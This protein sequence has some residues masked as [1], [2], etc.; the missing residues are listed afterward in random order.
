MPPLHLRK[1]QMT[2]N[3][4]HILL[5]IARA[6]IAERLRAPHETD[7]CT[8][9]GWLY[10]T[11]ACF[12]T[13]HMNGALRGCIGSIEA[14]RPI[15][16][17][18]RAN[19]VSAA[20]HDPR[21]PPLAE[22][23]LEAVDIEVSLLTPLQPLPVSSEADAAAKL[24]PSR[25]GVVLKYGAHRGTFLPQVWEQL[26]EPEHFLMHLKQKAGLSSDFWH[27]DVELFRYTVEKYAE[28]P[29]KTAP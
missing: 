16:E 2:E 8:D 4:G 12:V 11:A 21:F 17:D 26:P 22:S 23:E 29:E 3:K 7:I 18:L 10:E 6:A 19:A 13:L 20:F 24:E 25:D 27:E 28:H 15:L 5:S 1:I 14:H 9:F